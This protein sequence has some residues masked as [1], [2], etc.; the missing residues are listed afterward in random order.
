MANQGTVYRA[1]N[2]SI[3]EAAKAGRIDKAAQGALIAVAR[4]VARV[5]DDPEWPMV[6]ADESGRGKLDNVSPSVLLKYCEA[7]GICPDLSRDERKAV[8]TS[9]SRL[10]DGVSVIKRAG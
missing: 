10:R 3:D 6:C 2:R 1:L 7:L 4:K 8:K 9:L 5:M